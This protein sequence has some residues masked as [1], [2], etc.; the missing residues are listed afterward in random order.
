[1]GKDIIGTHSRSSK[2]SLKRC[3]KAGLLSAALL[4]S[5]TGLAEAA[6][7]SATLTVPNGVYAGSATA[8]IAS[9]GITSS[10]SPVYISAQ[11]FQN[12]LRVF[13]TTWLQANSSGQATFELGPTANWTGGSADCSASAVQEQNGRVRTLDTTNFHVAG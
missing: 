13:A 3:L 4:A 10:V 6:R 12:G 8:T 7:S 9:T 5:V 1:M 2:V 11:C